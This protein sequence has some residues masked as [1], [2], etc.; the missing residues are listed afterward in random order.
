MDVD[1]LRKRIEKYIKGMDERL[2]NIDSAN[3][4]VV[5]LARLYTEDSKYYLEKGD[6]VTALVDIV[7]AEGLLDAKE[8]YEN[9]D[10]KSN[11]SKKV[12]VAGTFDILHPGHIEFLKEASK[13]GRVYVTVARDSNSERIKGRKPI[14][15]EQT[16]L[17]IIKSVRYVFDAILG[18]Q[19]DFLKSVERINPDIIFLGPDQRVDETKFLEELKKRGLSPQ[20]IR[21]NE[22]IRK[23]P[24]SSTTDII[25]EIKKRYCKLEQR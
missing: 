14:N 19:E 5:E 1:E 6:Y 11:V 2:K 23:W 10:P 22:R 21:L 20:I 18:D 16:R 25:N 24:H 8:I 3:N 7:Y 17:E 13:Y 4:K 12:F 9:N 15:D